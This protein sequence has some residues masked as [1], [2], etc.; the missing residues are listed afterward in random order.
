MA[1]LILPSQRDVLTG[2][3]GDWFD[4]FSSSSTITIHKEPIHT[5]VEERPDDTYWG[6][7]EEQP[8][9]TQ[10]F[11]PVS[12]T[13]PAIIKYGPSQDDEIMRDVDIKN[14]EGGVTI[15]VQQDAKDYIASGVTEKITFDDKHW[16]LGGKSTVKRFLNRKTYIY[17][18]E[19][20]G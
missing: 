10:T 19:E 8:N 9:A 4:T 11:T 12:A 6:Y 14:M 13:Y 3:M 16:K 5:V 7:S 2:A 18:M 15:Q 20:V 17:S 1:N